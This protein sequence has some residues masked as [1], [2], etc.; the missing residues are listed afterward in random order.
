MKLVG[1][2]RFLYLLTHT[3][4][5]QVFL[6]LYNLDATTLVAYINFS[7]KDKREGCH[8]R[9]QEEG[10]SLLPHL[11]WV[12]CV[13]GSWLPCARHVGGAER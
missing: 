13:A 6:F 9:G 7:K 11:A 5:R 8:L 12:G 1:I 4:P 2:F 10:Q 3:S